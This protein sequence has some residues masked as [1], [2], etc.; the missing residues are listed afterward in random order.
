MSNNSVYRKSPK[1]LKARYKFVTV[2]ELF[3][4]KLTPDKQNSSTEFF[5]N[6]TVD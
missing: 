5:E 2:T 1:M 6:P 4:K 3:F